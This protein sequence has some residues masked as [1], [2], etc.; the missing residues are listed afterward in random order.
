MCSTPL[1]TFMTFSGPFLT[2]LHLSDPGDPRAGYSTTDRILWDQ[3]RRA[4]SPFSAWQPHYFWCTQDILGF[5]GCKST[6]DSHVEYFI[7]CTPSP[8]PQGC[9]QSIQ[10]PVC[11]DTGDCSN[12]CAGPCIW[13]YWTSRGF[14]LVLFPTL[15]RSFWMAYFSSSESTAPLSVIFKLAEGAFSSTVY[16][17]DKDIQ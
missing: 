14:H 8:S 11:T 17:V 6:S 15:A 3:S 13:P 4:E 9:S 2:D 10:L 1:K 12:P 5:L 16:V 7:A